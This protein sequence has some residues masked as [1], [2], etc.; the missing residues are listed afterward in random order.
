[1]CDPQHLRIKILNMILLYFLRELTIMKFA[2][3]V[4]SFS[5][6]LVF[7]HGHVSLRHRGWLCDNCNRAMGMLGDDERSMIEALL[8]IARGED[9]PEWIIKKIEELLKDF[10][11]LGP[12]KCIK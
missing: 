11:E 8:Y 5:I 6:K 10:L 2:F 3:F 12:P 7:D 9:R 4:N 1:M